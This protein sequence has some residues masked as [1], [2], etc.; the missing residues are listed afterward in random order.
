M[1]SRPPSVLLSFLPSPLFFAFS[2]RSVMVKETDLLE[3]RSFAL[4]TLACLAVYFGVY[5]SSPFLSFLCLFFLFLF[6]FS[7]FSFSVSTAF[8]SLSFTCLSLA[9]SLCLVFTLL[10]I[11][12]LCRIRLYR[13]NATNPNMLAADRA[14]GNTMEQALIFLRLV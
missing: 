6:R 2:P 7:S 10:L 3:L 1:P 13:Y 4:A 5:C 14:V 12:T 11:I 8:V 9:L